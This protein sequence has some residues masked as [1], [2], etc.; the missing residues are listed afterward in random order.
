MK[1]AFFKQEGSY[2]SIIKAA[3]AYQKI[4]NSISAI[5]ILQEFAER[6]PNDAKVNY[7]HIS[8]ALLPVSDKEGVTKFIKDELEM[9][10]LQ[11]IRLDLDMPS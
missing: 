9:K 1:A 11:L 6:F 4:E 7:T 8:Y 2:K 5:A 10:E 3:I